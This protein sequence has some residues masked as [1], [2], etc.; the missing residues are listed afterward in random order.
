LYF[1]KIKC[2]AIKI[3][4]ISSLLK[5]TTELWFLFDHTENVHAPSQ[6]GENSPEILKK[7]IPGLYGRDYG[8]GLNYQII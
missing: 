5:I 7:I 3:I 2:N 4:L 1:S 6:K 8:N